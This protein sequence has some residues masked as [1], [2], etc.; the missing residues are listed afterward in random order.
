[1]FQEKQIL[2]KTLQGSKGSWGVFLWFLWIVKGYKV[3]YNICVNG[4]GLLKH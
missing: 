2:V 3:L 4:S 1:M